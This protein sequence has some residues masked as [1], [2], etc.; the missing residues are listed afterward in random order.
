MLFKRMAA[1]MAKPHLSGLDRQVQSQLNALFFST[2]KQQFYASFTTIAIWGVVLTW[3]LQR[4]DILIWVALTLL[5]QVIRT[6]CYMAYLRRPAAD[7]DP[8]LGESLA[9]NCTI[10]VSMLYAAGPWVLFTPDSLLFNTLIMTLFIGILATGATALAP[11]KRAMTVFVCSLGMSLTLRFGTGTEVMYL[12]LAMGI[13]TIAMV[14]LSTGVQTHRMQRESIRL[15]LEKQMLADDL[16]EQVSIATQASAAATRASQGK[17]RFLAAASHDLRQ[18][19]HALTLFS[20]SLQ[21]KLRHTPH[22]AELDLLQQSVVAM[23]Q[24]LH[25][26]LDVSQLDAGVVNAHPQP[27]GVNALFASLRQAYAE[28]ANDKGL[29][30]RFRSG[31]L[32][33]E[34]DPAL[35]LRLVGNLVDNAIKYTSAGGV[36]VAARRR[37]TALGVQ[38]QIEVRDSG[39]GIPLEHHDNVFHEFFQVGNPGRDR[40]QGLG[41]GLSVVQRLVSLQGFSLHMK[42]APGCGTTFHL[43]LPCADVGLAATQTSPVRQG[44]DDSGHLAAA[45]AA[46]HGKRVLVV[47]DEVAILAALSRWLEALGVEAVTASDVP[48]ALRIAAQTPSFD[49]ALLDQR[50]GGSH[51]GLDLARSL[52]E[53]HGHHLPF[54]II[55]GESDPEHIQA[56]QK[57]GACICFKPLNPDELTLTMAQLLSPTSAATTR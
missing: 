23:N 27:V 13:C 28:R 51:Q 8:A 32:A 56:M 9:L 52:T 34:A 53:A 24:S 10:M 18:P 36:L 22:A 16:K 41:I 11:M 20:S 15:G 57:T 50:I 5:T 45:Q 33:V 43:R 42:S 55:T 40:Q 14:F 39:Q 6:R 2:M 35:L 31:G 21:K 26:M 48:A 3:K 37:Q 47:D 46:L 54:I 25:A 38:V 7:D 49:L 29:A 12:F 1:N 44:P 17:T 30:L 4:P 19:L